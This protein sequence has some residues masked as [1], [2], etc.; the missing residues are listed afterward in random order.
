METRA[1]GAAIAASAGTSCTTPMTVFTATS[2]VGSNGP[3]C[4]AYRPC[5]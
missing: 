4:D 5:R 2:T 3:P 1:G